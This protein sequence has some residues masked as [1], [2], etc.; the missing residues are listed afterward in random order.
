MIPANTISLLTQRVGS[1][2]TERPLLNIVTEDDRKIGFVI[3]D[4]VWRWRLYEYDRVENSNAFDELFGKLF[5]YLSITDDKSK[6]RSYPI[7]QEFP[8]TAPVIFESQVYNEIYEPIY[9]N[10]VELEITNEAGVRTKYSYTLSPGNAQY[11]IGD[12]QEGVYRYVSKTDLDG[13]PQTVRGE[14]AV[15]AQ[16]AELQNLTADFNLLRQL[17][18]STGGK[19]YPISQ[20]G[21]MLD[22]LENNKVSSVIRSE[23]TFDSALNL[24]WVFSVLLLLISAEWFMRKYFGSY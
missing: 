3:G 21:V 14:F 9:G 6:F 23:E 17:S 20:T 15:I 4:G 24:T 13:K 5:Q 2:T 22:Q 11:Q 7:K 12:L 18:S 1:V 8:D 16:Q 10:T 19:F